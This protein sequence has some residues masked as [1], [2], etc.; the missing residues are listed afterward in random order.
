MNQEK[1]NN[2]RKQRIIHQRVNMSLLKEN[3]LI[4]IIAR[5]PNKNSLSHQS[6]CIFHKPNLHNYMGNCLGMIGAV[7]L[8]VLVL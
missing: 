7:S 3:I 5:L 4:R 6:Q 1:K 8:D 2:Y